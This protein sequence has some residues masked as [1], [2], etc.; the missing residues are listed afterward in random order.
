MKN[1]LILL[2]FFTSLNLISQ[3]RISINDIYIGEDNIA[4]RTDNDQKFTGFAQKVRKNGHVVYEDQFDNGIIISHSVFFNSSDKKL[5]GKMIYNKDKP[6]VFEKFI[7]YKS[8][9]NGHWTEVEYY[10]QNGHKIL[11]EIVSDGKTTYRCEFLNGKKHGTESCINKDGT[12][13]TTEYEN[14]KKLK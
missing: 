13:L 12:E 2:M 11:E 14:G 10:D 7:E 6:F 3:E 9:R 1:I 4:Y 8:N 5:A